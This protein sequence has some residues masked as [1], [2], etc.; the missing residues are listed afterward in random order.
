MGG[1]LEVDIIWFLAGA[2]LISIVLW[3]AFETIVL[4]RLVTRE[5]RLTR[6]FFKYTWRY[7]AYAARSIRSRSRREHFLGYFGP[8]FMILLI[9][10]WA[11]GLI[12]GFALLLWASGTIRETPLGPAGF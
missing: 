8:L 11:T 2:A 10:L 3:D 4:P 12:T 9:L 6:L 5:I 7:W 1:E